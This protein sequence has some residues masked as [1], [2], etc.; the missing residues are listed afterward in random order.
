MI[1]TA[2]ERRR[3]LRRRQRAAG[4]AGLELP[5][6]SP[7]AARPTGNTLA[8]MGPQ[9]GYY[10]PEIVEQMHLTGPGIEAQGA[11]VPGP[12]D[13]HP[14]RP[15]AG[16]RVEPHLGRPRRPRRVRR[17]AVQPGR[18]GADARVDP[19]PATRARA[20]PMETFDAGTLNGTPITLPDDGARPGDRHGDRAAASRTRS[21]RKRSTFGRDGAEPRRAQG[22]DRRQGDDAAEVLRRPPTSS[23]SRSTGPTCRRDDDRVLLVG[24][25]AACARRAS[26]A[27]CRRSA[28][29]SYEWQGFLSRGRAPPRHR[30]AR[31]ACC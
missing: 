8:V 4:P 1:G 5:G 15:H 14:H 21:T 17:A 23:A 31:A 11:A 22:H 19:L 7:R 26:T 10:Y 13:V 6:R 18:L 30:A 9:L 16:L 3:H 29:A 2:P 25:A 28:P 12:G 27:G 24:P 20:R